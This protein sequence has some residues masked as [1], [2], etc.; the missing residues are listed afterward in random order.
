MG[1]REWLIPQEKIFFDFLDRQISNVSKGA[2]FL[3]K[4]VRNYKKV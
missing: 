1:I 4:L 3:N 2:K